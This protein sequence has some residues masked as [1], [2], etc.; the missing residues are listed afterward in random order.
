[1]GAAILTENIFDD[2]IVSASGFNILTPPSNV[3]NEQVATKWSVNADD[4]YLVFDHGAAVALDTVALIGVTGDSPTFRIRRS[5]TDATGATGEVANVAGLTGL[6]YFDSNYGKF[7]YLFAASNSARYTRIDIT[8][9]GVSRTA[10]GRAVG[11]VRDTFAINYQAPWTRAP[12]RRSP[13]TEAISG[14]SF[15]DRRRGYFK[16][17]ARFGFLS[18]T[19]RTTF[20]EEIAVRTVNEGHADMLWINDADSTN[21][22]RDCIWGYQL[23]DEQPV[24]QEL[25]VVP[26]VY[27]VE[28][29]LRDRN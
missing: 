22:S 23:A 14:G 10:V 28:F 3:Q 16:I 9:P 2:A 18:E 25:Y 4:A 29:A 13:I 26:P 20:L 27:S 11:G 19:E 17:A 7:V 1:M 6:P 8:E 21:L 24:T 5:S 15:I 12:V